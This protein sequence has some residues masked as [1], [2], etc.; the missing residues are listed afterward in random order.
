MIKQSLQ[1]RMQQKLSPQQIQVIKLLEI[2]VMELEQRIKREIEENPVLEEGAEVDEDLDNDEELEIARHLKSQAFTDD[3][4]QEEMIVVMPEGF[5]NAEDLLS[6]LD[7]KRHVL[8]NRE[9]ITLSNSEFVLEKNLPRNF[10]L[11]KFLSNVKEGSIKRDNLDEETRENLSL[12]LN[13]L[14]K[15][16]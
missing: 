1:Q 4:V 15:Y 2:P 8:H 9:G 11:S 14:Q 3:L 7:F 10:L 13:V 6:T 5:H 12:L 16:K